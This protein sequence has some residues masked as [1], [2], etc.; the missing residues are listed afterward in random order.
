MAGVGII[1]LMLYALTNIRE[2][3][4]GRQDGRYLQGRAQRV[5]AC[6]GSHKDASLIVFAILR[7][8]ASSLLL[9][10]P[11]DMEKEKAKA[12]RRLWLKILIAHR[13][14]THRRLFEALLAFAQRPYF[15]CLWVIQELFHGQEIDVYC[16]PDHQ[17]FGALWGLYRMSEKFEGQYGKP[18][19][20][21]KTARRLWLEGRRRT[22]V[23]RETWVQ[24]RDLLYPHMT[25]MKV[26]RSQKG[27]R[28]R[29]DEA[30]DLSRIGD[31]VCQDP[32]DRV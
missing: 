24:F 23:P 10:T 5:L 28:M 2:E 9:F 29:L 22:P 25:I 27:E 19:V 17:S 4:T 6:V 11:I 3:R 32:R 12:R 21:E 13:T 14:S 20:F 30:M 18:A 8:H 15:R 7:R 26:S 31:L 16:G 1:G